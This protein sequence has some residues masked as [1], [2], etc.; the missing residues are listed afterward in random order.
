[1][2]DKGHHRLEHQTRDASTQHCAFDSKTK[3]AFWSDSQV[4]LCARTMSQS[5]TLSKFESASGQ[6]CWS[7][8]MR[9]LADDLPANASTA[10]DI[11]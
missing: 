8:G 3:V 9:S 7:E 10:D 2:A 5:P 11:P 4:P 6:E 1:M